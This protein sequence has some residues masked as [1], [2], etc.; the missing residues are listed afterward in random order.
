MSDAA[1]EGTCLL[2]EQS[3]S[4][5]TLNLGGNGFAKKG[6]AKIAK[7]FKFRTDKAG[8]KSL[9]GFTRESVEIAVKAATDADVVMLVPAL[10]MCHTNVYTCV[11]AC[12]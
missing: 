2:I 7:A 10:N 9:L 4:I 6:A 12:A 11:R 3:K 5:E 8:V 1:A